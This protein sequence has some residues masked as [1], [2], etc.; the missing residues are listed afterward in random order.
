L[1]N[2]SAFSKYATDIDL[3]STYYIAKWWG[4]L[5]EQSDEQG[6]SLAV[7]IT[8][9]A[10]NDVVEDP[11]TVTVSLGSAEEPAD[12]VLF[13]KLGE[14]EC[15]YLVDSTY[16]CSADVSGIENG[17]ETTFTV[18]AFDTAQ[19]YGTA[20]VTVW[21]GERSFEGQCI[22]ANNF[23]HASATPA[24]AT[25]TNFTEY[26]AVGSEDSLGGMLVQTS[27]RETAP[28]YWTKVD[29]CE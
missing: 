15:T 25:T 14:S 10:D 24:R 21:V 11:V 27:L 22:T 8:D 2:C 7:S 29:S 23:A 4:L 6:P 3:H 28:G 19:G 5:D 13:V 9:P 18:T 17:T 26:L 1:G 12:D 16:E 20:S